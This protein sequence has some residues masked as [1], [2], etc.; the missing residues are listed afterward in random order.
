MRV[1][2]NSSYNKTYYHCKKENNYS[3]LKTPS[4]INFKADPISISQLLLSYKVSRKVESTRKKWI[5]ILKQKKCFAQVFENPQKHAQNILPM[6]DILGKVKS[7][8]DESWGYII[9]MKDKLPRIS[10]MKQLVL[11]KLFPLLD[12]N[13]GMVRNSK[14]EYMQTLFES[15]EY[16]NKSYVKTFKNMS[17][18]YYSS[19]KKELADKV[20]YS[21]SNSKLSPE[22]YVYNLA[23]IKT[24]DNDNYASYLQNNINGFNNLMKNI[25]DSAIKR[26]TPKQN[27]AFKCYSHNFKYF[28]K[29][30]DSN[31][32]LWQEYYE[33]AFYTLLKSGINN[34]QELAEKLKIDLVFAED[35]TKDL[36]TTVLAE[37][38]PDKEI[39]LDLFKQR[40]EEK[41]DKN[42]WNDNSQTSLNLKKMEK[43][44]DNIK[45][46]YYN[47]CN[48]IERTDY[49][50]E[51]KLYFKDKLENL[52]A[53]ISTLNHK[54]NK[55]REEHTERAIDLEVSTRL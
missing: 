6:M 45:I 41:F 38:E 50:K 51:L 30:Y 3:A 26:I 1:D 42:I 55:I 8:I 34:S 19:F 39:Q 28:S 21:I 5:N 16:Q 32:N 11:T 40:I 35:I 47:I 44:L 25:Y 7:N 23:I 29:S 10:E 49:E 24:M 43:T 15:G 20:F 17:D 27:E 9:F 37:K 46:K 33:P 52:E 53:R 2:F 48:F 22:H 14:K 18:S 12:D 4:N 13:S 36:N 31:D 54:I